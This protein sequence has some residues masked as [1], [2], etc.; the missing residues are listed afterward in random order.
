MKIGLIVVC[1]LILQLSIPFVLD[2]AFAESKTFQVRAGEIRTLTF[3]LGEGDRFEFWISV[4]G[5]SGNDVNLRIKD[6]YDV[7]IL[8]GLVSNQYNSQFTA[9]NSGSYEFEFDNSFSI[10][11]AKT[12]NFSYEIWEKPVGSYGIVGMEWLIIVIVVVVI[13]VAS[14][15]IGLSIRKKRLESRPVSSELD[16]ENAIKKAQN[17]KALDIL[18]SRLVKGEITKE[19]YDNL[20][21]E[22]E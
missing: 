9:A 12:V 2:N 10:I 20:K 13:I 19:E 18:K 4:S 5:G 11:S 16:Q 17:Q 15:S 14:V 7:R 6:P 8:Q 22:F 21:K 1:F 3:S